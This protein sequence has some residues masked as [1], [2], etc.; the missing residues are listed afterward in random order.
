MGLVDRL[1][2]HGVRG[3]MSGQGWLLGFMPEKLDST[4]YRGFTKEDWRVA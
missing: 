1:D 4:I 3:K 2:G